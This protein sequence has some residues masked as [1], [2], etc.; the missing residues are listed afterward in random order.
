MVISTRVS[1][2]IEKGKYP[3]AY[4]FPPKKGIETR[5]PVTGLDFASLYPSIIM[6]Y[7]LSP[8]KFIFDPKD[9]DIAQ[10]NGNNL[11]KIEFSFNKDIVQAWCIRHDSQM[12]KKGLYPAVLEDLFNKRLELKAR[13][14]PLGKKKRHLEKIISSAKERDKRIPESLNSEYSTVYFE[15]DY[16]DS[17]QKALKVYMNTFMEKRK[18]Q[19]LQSFFAN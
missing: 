3:G 13:L 7:N 6:A 14:A 4:V 1:G 15:Y 19:N 2:N 17:K 9:A 10:N 16:L 18:T 8:E 5:R 11:H 12:E